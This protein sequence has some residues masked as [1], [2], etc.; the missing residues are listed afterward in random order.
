MW[1]GKTKKLERMFLY[2]ICALIR[3]W[4][5]L[6]DLLDIPAQERTRFENV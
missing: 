5:L 1:K 6:R 2:V 4:L 3:K